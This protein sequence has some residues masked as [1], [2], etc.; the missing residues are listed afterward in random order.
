MDRLCSRV[1]TGV[2]VRQGNK[3]LSQ[4]P[5][6]LLFFSGWTRHWLSS[7]RSNRQ[8]REL[9]DVFAIGYPQRRE[10]DRQQ[11]EKKM[12]KTAFSHQKRRG[13]FKN[14]LS[15]SVDLMK[16]TELLHWDIVSRLKLE[17]RSKVGL[18]ISF[19]CCDKY[20]DPKQLTG[21]ECL[22]Q[23]IDHRPSLGKVRT[24]TQGRN[25]EGIPWRNAAGWLAWWIMLSYLF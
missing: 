3:P 10:E 7:A 12:E 14:Q 24:G 4:D 21:G 23:C 15:V 17:L 1:T 22:F 19:C 20:P 18:L 11:K 6:F 9:L 8:G 5:F 2:G 25:H 16:Q 13:V